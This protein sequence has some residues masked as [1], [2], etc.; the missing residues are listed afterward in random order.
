M[1]AKSQLA[2]YSAV[3]KDL[4]AKDIMIK[5]VISL[6]SD[7]RISQA[8]EMMRIKKISG[9]PIVDEEKKV[10]GII[11]I[12]DIINALEDSIINDPIKLLMTKNVKTIHLDDPLTHVVELFENFKFGRFPVVDNNNVLNGII[13][14]E[15]ILHGILGKFDLLYLHDEKRKSTLDSERSLI[16]GETLKTDDAEFHY[17][18]S[19][20]DIAFAG[21]GAALLKNYLKNKD[22]DPDITRK[23]GI[24]TYEAETN[25]VIHSKG[26]GDIYCFCQPDRI[27]VRVLDDGIGIDDLDQAMIEGFTT[28]SD[29]VRE[30]GFGAGMG[31]PN[32]N[33]FSDKL[34]ILSDKNKGTQVE[35]VFYLNSK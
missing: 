15:D 3:F 31:I 23:V 28:A 13:T 30:L 32:M 14:I 17:E 16:T 26:K 8:K 7:K 25:V 6:S 5:N 22:F 29:Y 9:I 33:R 19:S 2:R 18:L 20:S 12:E 24:T 11:S 1:K 4:T 35:M 21:T 27:I 10:I 34:V